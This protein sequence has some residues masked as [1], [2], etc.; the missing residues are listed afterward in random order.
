MNVDFRRISEREAPCT[1]AD[2]KN[3]VKPGSH[4]TL[5]L[6]KQKWTKTL[7]NGD[8]TKGTGDK[9]G[10]LPTYNYYCCRGSANSYT[11]HAILS[12]VYL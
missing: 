8:D 5:N 7:V 3:C 11:T 2:P 9:V 4:L 6:I 10:Q 12:I 1:E